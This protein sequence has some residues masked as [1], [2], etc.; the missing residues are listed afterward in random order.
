MENDHLAGFSADV[1]STV[2]RQA[3]TAGDASTYR[4][5]L[6]RGPGR[7]DSGR[8][9]IDVQPRQLLLRPPAR[10][11][12]ARA[13]LAGLWLWHDWLEESHRISQSIQTATGSFWHAIMHRREGD[14]ANSKYWYARCEGHEIVDSLA[15]YAG[16]IVNNLPADKGLLRLVRTGWD[17]QVFVD[18]V[19]EVSVRAEDP[20][21]A[22]L[23]ELQRV[24]WRLLFEY[25]VRKAA[26]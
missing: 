10:E 5:L 23:V 17:A 1:L 9:L 12:Y 22:S 19:E 21:L 14:F 26:E 25:C 2:A 11:E 20:R 16:S 15:A 4:E 6:V 13:M 7:R 18:L 8:L 3:L 24:E